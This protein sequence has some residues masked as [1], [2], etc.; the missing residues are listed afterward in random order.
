MKVDGWLGIAEPADPET[1]ACEFCDARAEHVFEVEVG[2][3]R[4]L[5][6][7]AC[8]YH[9]NLAAETTAKPP[10]QHRASKEIPADQT[11]LSV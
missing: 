7:Y 2:K 6:V 11:K 4:G 3:Q 10:P 9:R 1:R 5:Y 8:P